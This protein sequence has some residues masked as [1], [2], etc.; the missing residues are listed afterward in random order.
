MKTTK[1]FSREEEDLIRSKYEN[2]ETFGAIA[3]VRQHPLFPRLCAHSDALLG[4]GEIQIG[5]TESV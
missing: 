2:G 5:S 3:K 1:P 4:T